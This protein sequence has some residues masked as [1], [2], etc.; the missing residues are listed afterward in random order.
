MLSHGIR[1]ISWFLIAFATVLQHFMIKSV[2]F[3]MFKLLFWLEGL[4]FVESRGITFKSTW[5][6]FSSTLIYDWFRKVTQQ[7]Q[8]FR[9]KKKKLNPF[10]LPSSAFS[11]VFQ[12]TDFLELLNISSHKVT[13]LTNDLQYENRKSHSHDYAM[14]NL[15]KMSILLKDQQTLPFTKMTFRVKTGS[16]KVPCF[17]YSLF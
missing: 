17:P 9:T 14:Q 3:T 2:N 11:T 5:L 8:V 15:Q 16:E 6:N 4:N 1:C 12:P 7:Y 10:Y 13:I